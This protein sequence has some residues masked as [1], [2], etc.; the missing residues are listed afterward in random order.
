MSH[1]VHSIP[2]RLRVKARAFKNQRERGDAARTLLAGF[3]GV[4]SVESNPATGSLLI[5]YD[6]SVTGSARLLGAL[7]A[8]G[9]IELVSEPRPS[10]NVAKRARPAT[11]RRVAE[12]VSEALPGMIA[13]LIADKLARLAAV[14]LVRAV[15]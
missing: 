6:E 2:G 12:T 7:V 13:D 14:A 8:E 5:R 11:W 9:L 1:Y 3:A 15:I 10:L 4:H